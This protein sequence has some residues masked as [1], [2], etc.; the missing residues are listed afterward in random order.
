MCDPTNCIQF[1][2]Q[3]FHLISKKKL[4]FFAKC[5]SRNETVTQYHPTEHWQREFYVSRTITIIIYFFIFYHLLLPR[6]LLQKGCMCKKN[7]SA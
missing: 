4:K 5:D 7:M 1:I 3:W 6:F 2:F